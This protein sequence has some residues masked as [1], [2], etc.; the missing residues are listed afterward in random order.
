MDQVFATTT[1]F[2]RASNVNEDI[3]DQILLTRKRSSNPRVSRSSE[4]GSNILAAFQ[5]PATFNICDMPFDF[6]KEQYDGF[7][8]GAEESTHDSHFTNQTRST[9]TFNQFILSA[10]D[11]DLD[12]II[13]NDEKLDKL[14]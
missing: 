3:V 5:S 13:N 1:N 2:L 4:R 9:T 6:N 14:M 10:K 12:E 7:Y 8:Y 11:S